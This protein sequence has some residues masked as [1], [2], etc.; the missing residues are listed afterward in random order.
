LQAFA[1]VRLVLLPTATTVVNR[2]ALFHD[3]SEAGPADVVPLE[4][5]LMTMTFPTSP[6]EKLP[7]GE[8]NMVPTHDPS[9]PLRRS[10]IKAPVLA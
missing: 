1:S 2:G 8:E 6:V 4:S 7:V 5:P 10:G 3:T 9:V